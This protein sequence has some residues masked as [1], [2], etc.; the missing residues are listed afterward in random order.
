MASLTFPVKVFGLA[1]AEMARAEIKVRF[2]SRKTTFFAD[3]F[4]VRFS[5]A[6]GFGLGAAGVKIPTLFRKERERRMG[7]PEWGTLKG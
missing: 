3:A 4:I 1:K 6:A 2:K 7:H 5:L